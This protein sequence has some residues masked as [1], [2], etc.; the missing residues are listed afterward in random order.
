M[1]GQGNAG[2]GGQHP[3]AW[4][5]ESGLQ[6]KHPSVECIFEH[7]GGILDWLEPFCVWASIQ[8]VL[9]SDLAGVLKCW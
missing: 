4:E 9:D 7:T 3:Q 2:H 1:R 6:L 5:P 8:L